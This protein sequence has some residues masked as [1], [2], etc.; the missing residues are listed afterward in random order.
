LLPDIHA[1]IEKDLADLKK[2]AEAY[3]KEHGKPMPLP[4][5]P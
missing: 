1:L 3:E 2:R 5:V 4:K